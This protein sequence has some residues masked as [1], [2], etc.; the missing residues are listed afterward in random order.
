L[1]LGYIE[2]ASTLKHHTLILEINMDHG[3]FATIVIGLVVGVVAKFIHPGKDNLGWILTVVLG[4][5][6]SY[7]G[8][9]VLGALNIGGSMVLRFIAAVAGAVVLLI[10]YGL[11]VGKKSGNAD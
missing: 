4:I 8:G 2:R 7:I 11:V 10:V 6:G 5:A 1:N 9:M 3:I